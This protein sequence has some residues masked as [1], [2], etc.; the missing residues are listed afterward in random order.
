MKTKKIK[1]TMPSKTSSKIND[2]ETALVALI[3]SKLHKKFYGINNV[4]CFNHLNKDYR[5][6]Q[7]FKDKDDNKK[8][9]IRIKSID[10][11][12]DV[13]SL[14]FLINEKDKIIY[15]VTEYVD[16]ITNCYKNDN[17]ILS[18]FIKK[19]KKNSCI[20]F[21]VQNTAYGC[22]LVCFENTICGL[23]EKNND[24]F[25]L[26]FSKMWLL[27]EKF[28][29]ISNKTTYYSKSISD[30]DEN[31]IALFNSSLTSMLLLIALDL[32][33]PLIVDCISKLFAEY[34][35]KKSILTSGE[36]EI[37]FGRKRTIYFKFINNELSIRG[38][39]QD[40]N[41]CLFNIINQ[42]SIYSTFESLFPEVKFR[43][44][45]VKIKQNENDEQIKNLSIEGI[46]LIDKINDFIK[47]N[48]S[49][50]Y[51]DNI[52]HIFLSFDSLN[53]EELN[54]EFL[55]N[56]YDEF[57]NKVNILK[58]YSELPNHRNVYYSDDFDKV[59]R[60][61]DLELRKAVDEIIFN[62]STLDGME[63]GNYLKDKR[64][65]HIS[66]G[67][68]IR[69]KNGC[70]HRIMFVFGDKINRAK[71]DIYI[72]SYI[73]DHD[74]NNLE[75]VKPENQVY[76]K[77]INKLALLKL[78]KRQ[79][80]IVDYSGN[81]LLCFGCAGAGK[82]LISG[83][84]YIDIYNQ[85]KD[86]N[87]LKDDSLVYVTYNEH[88]KNQALKEISNV[89]NSVNI[90]TII[91]F[92]SNYCHDKIKH[93]KH[94]DKK[95]FAYYFEN[96]KDYKTIEYFKKNIIG[97][98]IDSIYTFY[99]GV[100]KGSM[101]ESKNVRWTKKLLTPYLRE[102]QFNL[103]M[104]SEFNIDDE[105]KHKLYNFFVSYSKFL[106]ENN[107]Y[108]DNDLARMVI[109]NSV[110]PGFKKYKNIIVDEVQD[111]TE[112]QLD[113]IVKCAYS[114]NKL[115]FFG[116]QNQ[117]IN[118]TLLDLD[119]IKMCLNVNSS[120]KNSPRLETLN[121]SYRF[122]P[123]FKD[124]LNNVLIKNRVNW[125]GKT[126]EDFEI[127][128][129]EST[130][131]KRWGG[132]SLNEKVIFN[133]LNNAYR[134]PNAKVLIPDLQVVDK[135]ESEELK[136]LIK[137]GISSN[138]VITIY[139]AKGL[140]WDYV[141]LFDML[142]YNEDK[143]LE[144]IN[145]KANHST[146]HRMIFNQFYVGCTRG[147]ISFAVLEDNLNEE[148]SKAMLDGLPIIDNANFFIDENNDPQIWYDNAISLFKG[149]FY[150]FA[151][152]D[153]I[154]SKKDLTNDFY[155]EVCSKMIDPNSE[156]TSE[157]A[158]KCSE[159]GFY[160]EALKMYSSESIYDN[161]MVTLMKLHLKMFVDDEDIKQL[162]ELESLD[163]SDIQCIIDS[164]FV[165]R[166]DKSIHNKID[167]I[168]KGE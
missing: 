108:D 41:V 69:I 151:Y 24:L 140:E 70:K 66:D 100:F 147:E 102:E 126:S 135:I 155:F 117:S 119:L 93:L 1:K 45:E 75:N 19:L 22:R 28:E 61:Q 159:Y 142:K 25:S 79:K 51:Q 85:Y 115:S 138:R 116:D 129:L 26:G 5:V 8:R 77:Y 137:E 72:Y 11:K 40:Q 88:V 83:H 145:G 63:L 59:C 10:D 92:F 133:L 67:I 80:Q 58:S 62:F 27:D 90:Y 32:Y 160:K 132:Y 163:E 89:V 141:V 161:L 35:F 118:P 46:R 9:K 111:L 164:G 48:D 43:E 97:N 136:Q 14:V 73:I 44:E 165:T 144:M 96:C 139:D 91:D 49:S 81:T 13:M 18:E 12:D 65:V 39:S 127:S 47:S 162:I 152:H 106:I 30:F 42:N 101:F 95:H 53:E 98:V 29:I 166:L 157:L 130:K 20:E 34:K 134:N 84:R 31:D 122:G 113:A 36:I 131:E 16:F 167:S 103:R 154:A 114:V 37:T 54:N 112:V 76:Q 107:L 110:I 125:I 33:K 128:P 150:K 4:Y 17:D 15:A 64:L 71:N 60:K 86:N 105:M 50:T 7:F 52:D 82:T 124:Y 123:L 94:V 149:G 23:I 56:K 21:K 120:S 146:L 153:F 156:F 68:K 148:V 55:C 6:F 168:L 57:L 143:Y 74:Y 109:E 104:D 3:G 78:D 2:I 38:E 99:M 121:E 158:Y 87:S